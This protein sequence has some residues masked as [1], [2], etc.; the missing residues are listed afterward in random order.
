MQRR[1]ITGALAGCL[2]LMVTGFTAQADTTAA[3]RL[4]TVVVTANRSQATLRDVTS[5]V[6]VITQAQIE[7][8]AAQNMAEL[9]SQNGFFTVDQGTHVLVQIRGMNQPSMGNE[10]QSPILMLLNGRRIGINNASL[11]GLANVERVEIIRGPSAVQYGPSAMGGVINIITKRGLQDDF[12]V[13]LESGIGSFGLHKESLSVNGGVQ[14]FDFALGVVNYGRDDFDMRNGK[15]RPKS[16][17]DYNTNV[18]FDVGYNFNATNRIGANINYYGTE[19]E[20]GPTYS[21]RET[22]TSWNNYNLS[23]YNVAFMYDGG[24]LDRMFNWAATYSFGRDKSQGKDYPMTSWTSDNKIDVQSGNVQFGYN[25]GF[26]TADLGV[27]YIEYDYK[28]NSSYSSVSKGEYQD[29]GVYLASK[30]RF[31]D[32][33]LI[34][35]LSGRYDHYETEVKG[36]G[37]DDD[38]RFSP[39][40]GVAFLPVEWL[41]LRGNYSQGFKM[42][43]PDQINA[44]GFYYISNNDLKPE[45]SETWEVGVDVYWQFIEAGLTYFYTNWKD[46]IVAVSVPGYMYQYQ[47]LESATMSGLEFAFSADF[48]QAFNWQSE[49]RPYVNFTYMI[50][51]ENK[52][53]ATRNDTKII[54]NVPNWMIN[55]GL[56]FSNVEYDLKANLNAVYT[57]K[58]KTRDYRGSWMDP[59]YGAY[60]NHT[61]NVVVNLSVEKGLFDIGDYGNV[62]LRADVNNL[63]DSDNEAYL[64]YPGSGRNF[65][66]GLVYFY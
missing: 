46:K 48:G 35:S 61:G 30:V 22:Y 31:F 40:V 55:F 44:S 34:F 59:G 21:T 49:V 45:K 25:S 64:D 66:A 63:F 42:A 62:K 52:D 27:D 6:T 9:L 54:T 56:N 53:P 26:I 65:Y 58:M 23:N 19:A 12:E 37:R 32:E 51:R 7:T 43:A 8:S 33:R 2:V 41:K 11:V 60:I 36:S 28:N 24:T 39:S 29:L 47:N 18:N 5:N 16:E 4:D 38:D 1:W 3:S 15:K 13:R 57:G 10:M 14:D 50:D 20:S 17:V